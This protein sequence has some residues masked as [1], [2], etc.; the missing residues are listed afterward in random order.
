MLTVGIFI[1]SMILVWSIPALLFMVTPIGPG[2]PP[3]SVRANHLLPSW[4]GPYNETTKENDLMISGN[5]S[6]DERFLRNHQ[7]PYPI[8]ANVTL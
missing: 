8:M 3:P 7:M 5:P 2:Y 1:F 4:N 6:S